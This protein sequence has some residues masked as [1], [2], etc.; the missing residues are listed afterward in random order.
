MEEL[1]YRGLG[2]TLL[3]PYGTWVSI[4]VTGVLFGL[5]HGLLVALPVLTAFGIVI[6]WLRARTDSIYPAIVLHAL[7]NGAALLVSVATAA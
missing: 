3:S 2:F 1:T 5:A 6:G 4:L 7:F